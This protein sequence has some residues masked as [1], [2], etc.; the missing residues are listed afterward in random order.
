MP[1]R[2]R[3]RHAIWCCGIF[4][5]AASF[6]AVDFPFHVGSIACIPTSSRRTRSRRPLDVQQGPVCAFRGPQKHIATEA[7]GHLNPLDIQEY[8]RHDGF[9]A[10]RRV[11]NEFHPTEIVAEIRDSGLRGRGGA[12]F[13]TH[14]KWKIV[15][16]AESDTKYVICNGDEGDPG[17]FMDRMLLESFPYRVIEGMLIA[18]PGGGGPSGLLLHS[19]RISRGGQT[20]QGGDP[21]L[22]GAWL[23]GGIDP[24]ARFQ[25]ST[26]GQAGSREPL[27]AVR[28]RR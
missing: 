15:Q 26:G 20:D 28:K 19:R 27:S 5:R 18:A 13:P 6:D 11:L 2:V 12:G 24:G 1:R 3:N 8:Q 21:L 9:V 25:L 17:A 16:D 7:C 23:S 4:S 14:I 10:L 22:S